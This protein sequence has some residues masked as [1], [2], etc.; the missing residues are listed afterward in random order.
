MSKVIKMQIDITPEMA[1]SLGR[2]GRWERE[3]AETVLTL[4]SSE[5]APMRAKAML[6]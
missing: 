4:H 1:K 3:S 5:A 2:V 6:R